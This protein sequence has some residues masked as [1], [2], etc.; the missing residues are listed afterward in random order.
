MKSAHRFLLVVSSA[1]LACCLASAFAAAA[2]SDD[3]FRPPAVVTQ[4]VPPVPAEL[5]ER[6]RQYQAVRS[7]AFRGWS[8]DGKGILIGTRFGNTA[9]LHRVYEPGGRRE[10]VTFF[11]EPVGG[12][13]LPEAT[14]G[15]LILT[16]GRG[17]DE[18]FQVLRLDPGSGRTTLL[19][20]GK[21]RNLLEALSLD[22]R[23]L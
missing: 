21:S 12:R 16:L 19:T 15:T 4:D 1:V 13:F 14:D 22:G 17:G 9:Q 8:P 23:G 3:P 11:E 6:L 7:A 2:G 10:Q 20:D 5:M 18:N